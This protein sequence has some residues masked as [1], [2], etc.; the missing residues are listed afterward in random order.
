VFQR[1]ESHSIVVCQYDL[2]RIN[3][4]NFVNTQLLKVQ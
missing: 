4:E 3:G 1:E 2:A